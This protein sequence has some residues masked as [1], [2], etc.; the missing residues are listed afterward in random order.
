ML[1]Q[2]RTNYIYRNYICNKEIMTANRTIRLS[3]DTITWW[4]ELQTHAQSV[5]TCS[6]TLMEKPEKYVKYVQC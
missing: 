2:S 3:W 6:K 5:F 4:F 1:L